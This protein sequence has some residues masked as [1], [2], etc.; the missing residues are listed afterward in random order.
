MRL[1]VAD[2]ALVH[3]ASALCLQ[4]FDAPEGL[5][6]MIDAVSPAID[7]KNPSMAAILMAVEALKSAQRGGVDP[8]IWSAQSRLRHVLARHHAGQLLAAHKV[9]FPSGGIHVVDA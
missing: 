1:T 9:I 2:Q 5:L 6:S 3:A 7:R 8:L 4:S